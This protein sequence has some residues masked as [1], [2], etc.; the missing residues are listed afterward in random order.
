MKLRSTQVSQ[1]TNDLRSFMKSNNAADV[2]NSTLFDNKPSISG[3][4]WA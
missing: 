3:G 2:G 1:A 4:K